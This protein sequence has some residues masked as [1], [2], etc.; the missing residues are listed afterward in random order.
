[1]DLFVRPVTTE[2]GDGSS[3]EMCH[4]ID[5]QRLFLAPDGTGGEVTLCYRCEGLRLFHAADDRVEDLSDVPAAAIYVVP[6][7]TH[8]RARQMAQERRP[9]E[10]EGG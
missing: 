9:E 1:M 10:G 8:Q 2:P 7:I 4:A 5:Y 3:C 6:V